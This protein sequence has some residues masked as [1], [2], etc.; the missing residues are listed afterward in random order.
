MKFILIE[1]WSCDEIMVYLEGFA[2]IDHDIWLAREDVYQ[3]VELNAVPWQMMGLF[4]SQFSIYSLLS[5]ISYLKL[6]QS[7]SMTKDYHHLYFLT[8]FISIGLYFVS[9][10]FISVIRLT[11]MLH[12]CLVSIIDTLWI[13]YT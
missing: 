1:K 12:E 11:T 13:F 9:F 7:L 8:Y 2:F 3:L 4:K 6:L 10:W 5:M